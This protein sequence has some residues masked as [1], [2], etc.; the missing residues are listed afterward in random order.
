MS[1]LRAQS[2][3]L[4][5][6][7]AVGAAAA[8]A[9]CTGRIGGDDPSGTRRSESPLCSETATPGPAPLRRL[10]VRE[11]NNTVRDLL[12]D[13]TEPGATLPADF[14]PEKASS[15]F[16]NDVSE[17]TVTVSHVEELLVVNEGIADRA[18]TDVAALVACDVAA[19]GEDACALGFVESFG[20]RAYRRPLTDEEVADLMSVFAVGRE[21]ADFREGIKLVIERALSSPHFL[22]RVEVE[23]TD[24]DGA[25][26]LSSHEVASRLSYFLWES[27]PD[28]ELFAAAEAGGLETQEEVAAQARRML[29]DPKGR[30]ARWR[31]YAQWLQLYRLPDVT[32]SAED[33]PTFSPDLLPH[34]EAE[35]RAFLEDV[36]K[37]GTVSDLIGAS[38]TFVS[39]ELASFYG[40]PAPTSPDG[41]VELDPARHAGALT[42]GGLLSV[43]AKFDTEAVVRRGKFVRFQ[44]LC[45]QFAPPANAIMDPAID[46]TKEP[47][48]TCHSRMDPIGESF[49]H[50]D[51]VGL[52]RDTADGQPIDDSAV[53]VGTDVDGEYAGVRGLA[54]KLNQ[55]EQFRR[56]VVTQHFRHASGRRE[57]EEDACS[58]DTA[59]L[60]FEKSGFDLDE[61]IVAITTSDSFRYRPAGEGQ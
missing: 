34:F 56:C 17:Q 22:Y 4:P 5:L 52:W 50:Y 6:V 37:N 23:G 60:G 49:E 1:L 31:F 27:M 33:Y 44:L 13:A 10:T 46:R 7:I 28:A 30:E 40:L 32:K 45:E 21:G 51:G 43:L 9:A 20:A 19:S 29:A 53:L 54:D 12:G 8:A 61:L 41:R 15:G 58:T 48:A 42:Q 18:T 47:C 55:S 26:L 3:L 14:P 39:P 36:Q 38:H 11:F 24:K 35:A 59:Y 25:V 2:R 57:A 16:E